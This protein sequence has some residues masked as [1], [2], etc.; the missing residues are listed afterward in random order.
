MTRATIQLIALLGY[1]IFWT[2]EPIN[3]Q[4]RRDF[5]FGLPYVYC[6]VC[7]LD[8]YCACSNHTVHT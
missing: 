5:M 3:P 2:T 6:Y 4:N 7:H 8:M 1:R